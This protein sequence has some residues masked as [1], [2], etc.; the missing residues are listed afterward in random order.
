MTL[1]L[2]KANIVLAGHMFHQDS[3]LVAASMRGNPPLITPN[4]E[5]AGFAYWSYRTP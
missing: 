4:V 1:P 5:T 3:C 2:G